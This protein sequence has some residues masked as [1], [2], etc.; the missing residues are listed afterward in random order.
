MDETTIE[1]DRLRAAIAGAAGLG[2]IAGGFETLSLPFRLATPMV[3]I[4]ALV[5]GAAAIAGMGALG[6]IGGL[7]L[8][9][10]LLRMLRAR[11]APVA[12]AWIVALLGGLLTGFYV[13][14]VSWVL[15]SESRSAAGLIIA[16]LPIGLAGIIWYNARYWVRRLEVGRPVGLGWM[17][18]ATALSLLLVGGSAAGFALREPRGT[19][20]QGR[21]LVLVTVDGLRRDAVG[22]L[23]GDP[24]P[25]IDEIGRMGMVFTDA[26]TPSPASGPANA[27][28]LSGL[29]P[30]RNRRIDDAAPLIRAVK[31]LPEVLA[32]QGYTTAAFVSRGTLAAGTGQAQGFHLY[33]DRFVSPWAR[34]RLFASAHDPAA[35]RSARATTQA[36]TRWLGDFDDRPVF[37]WVHLADPAVAAET[38]GDVREAALQV[39]ASV[40]QIREALDRL[41]RKNA[42][43]VIAGTYGTMNGEH[44]LR[45]NVGLYD[46]VVRVP[47]VVQ[48]PGYEPKVSRPSAQVRLMDLAATILE[49]LA[50]EPLLESEGVALL[51]Y[52][53]GVRKA[54]MSCPLLA[55]A[56]DGGWQLGL[57]N[58]GVKYIEG[59]GVSMLF[60]LGPDPGEEHDIAMEQPQIVDAARDLLTAEKAALQQLLERR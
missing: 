29:H 24:T 51:G 49:L 22:I 42:P 59:G 19:T 13:W 52:G 46:P 21:S 12:V 18:L 16:L 25:A 30:L 37:A 23:G 56:A 35:S 47:L 6:A 50:F 60:N 58:N 38:G 39:D 57:R 54:T 36:F 28:I 9:W 27:A 10:P 11:P 33:D 53:S 44:G 2:M 43:I 45:G 41:D 1:V 8:G 20:L 26:V 31:T 32:D 4:E 34:I 40:R 48:V 14:Q 17:A 5:A 3:G 7:V 55:H 15:W